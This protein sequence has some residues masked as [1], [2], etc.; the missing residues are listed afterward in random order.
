MRGDEPIIAIECKALG[1]SKVDDRGQLKRYFNAEKAV[2][3]GILTD[4]LVYE[5][6]VDSVEPNLMDDSPFMTLDLR[7]AAAGE[8]T[9]A[10]V[11]GL[12]AL[13]KTQYD[14]GT[15]SESARLGLVYR[16]FYSYFQREIDNPG[17]DLTRFLPSQN[18]I[19]H[20]RANALRT[21]Q[22]LARSAMRDVFAHHLLKKLD[23]GGVGMAEP[24]PAL[25]AAEATSPNGKG[26]ADAPKTE[27]TEVEQSVFD[28]IRR[29][30]AFLVA[31]DQEL[32]DRIERIAAKDYQGKFV[33]YLGMER[34][35]RILDFYEG[36]NG[37]PM[38]FVFVDD[39]NPVET[40]NV[41]TLDDRLVASFRRS[42]AAIGQ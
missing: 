22:D 40:T 11:K 31:G 14:P 1:S 35:G 16:A 7:A 19:R 20:I 32:Y 24:K 18:G 30:L 42:V 34:K 21:Y 26:N 25:Q 17:E 41:K 37:G 36:R 13:T 38:K 8:L 39:P 15:V 3:L 6:F 5:F 27:I 33:I 29:R 9:D 2:K 10:V 12:H 4:G 23:L 28:Y